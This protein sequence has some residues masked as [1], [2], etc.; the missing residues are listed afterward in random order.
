MPLVSFLIEISLIDRQ[1]LITAYGMGVLTR[2]YKLII[3]KKK[4]K[5]IMDEYRGRW[6]RFW[7][8]I[9]VD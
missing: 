9:Q 2:D 5:M 3:S 6:D 7:E 1:L 8:K 4:S